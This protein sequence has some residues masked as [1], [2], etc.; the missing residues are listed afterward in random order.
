LRVGER[1]C[2]RVGEVMSDSPSQKLKASGKVAESP[3][4]T[5]QII[6]SVAALLFSL[7]TSA[8]V[9]LLHHAHLKGLASLGYLGVLVISLLANATLII[10]APA[11][12]AVT[13]AAAGSGLN[14][15]LVGV[16]AGL[17]S[18][19]GEMTGYLAGYAGHT[20]IENRD[21]YN[22]ILPWI[23]RLGPVAI[24]ALAA[25]PNPLFDVAGIAAGALRMP[26]WL[27]FL[28][29]WAGKTVRMI[30]IAYTGTWSAPLLNRF[31]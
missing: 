4:K 1:E 15:L 18:A 5:R 24:F 27:F 22:R 2:E 23:R 12:I 13:F 21:F 10:P 16:F 28:S 29:C 14:P 30:L 26:L 17:G 9:F 25:I 6:M 19:V 8:G 11:G 20:V 7:L 31:V 3:A